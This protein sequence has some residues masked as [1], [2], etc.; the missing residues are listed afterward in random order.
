MTV[1]VDTDLTRILTLIS[2]LSAQISLNKDTLASLQRQSSTIKSQALHT[3]TGFALRRFNVDLTKEE[4]ESELE[5]NNAA[6]TLENQ[7]LWSENK[8][9]TGLMKDYEVTLESVMGK[10]RAYAV[11]VFGSSSTI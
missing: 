1:M 10:F 9:L 3:T 6:L 8:S 5:R 11:S 7:G 4:F 2:E